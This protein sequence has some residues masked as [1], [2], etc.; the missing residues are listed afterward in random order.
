MPARRCL[1]TQAHIAASMPVHRA[2]VLCLDSGWE[3]IGRESELNPVS[4]CTARNLAYVIYTSGS[5]GQPKGVMIEHRSLVNY[6]CWVNEG[7]L[8]DTLEHLPLT[9]KLTFDM[10]LKQ[11]FPP[12]LRGGEVWMLPEEV[13][14]QPAALLSALGARTKVGLNCVPSLWKAML[15]AVH[16]GQAID[17]NASARVPIVRRRTAE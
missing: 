14:A 16:S 7:L 17:P 4:R 2:H 3:A 6:L 12:L 9:T 10:C 11:L 8:G 5:T 13:V 1:L 15:H